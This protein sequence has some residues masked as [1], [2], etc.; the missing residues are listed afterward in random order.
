MKSPMSR[1]EVAA[2]FI[3]AVDCATAQPGFP[4]LRWLRDVSPKHGANMQHGRPSYYGGMD[5]L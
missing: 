1:A 4:L 3:I 5:P 2:Q